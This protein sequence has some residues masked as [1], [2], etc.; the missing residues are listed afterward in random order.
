MQNHLTLR[1]LTDDELHTIDRLAYA[2]TEPARSSVPKCSG[3]RIT[4]S[5]CS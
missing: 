4:A 1:P 5:A 2:R 3:G